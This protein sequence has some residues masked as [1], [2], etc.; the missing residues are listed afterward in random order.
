LH[1][2]EII[3]GSYCSHELFLSLLQGRCRCN[4]PLAQYLI[5]RKIEANFNKE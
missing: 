1:P 4:P 5:G 2:E 3:L